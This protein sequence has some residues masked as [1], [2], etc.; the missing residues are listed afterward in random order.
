MATDIDILI[1]ATD[2]ASGPIKKVEGE[3]KNLGATA[4]SSSS[5]LGGL[6]NVFKAGLTTALVGTAAAVGGLVFA[7]KDSIGAAKE[8]AQGQKQLAAVLTST[9][10]AAGVTVDAANDLASSLAKV[11][12][13][14]DDTILAGENMLLTFTNIGKD[15]FPRAT[16]TI[17]DMS[18][19]LGD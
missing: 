19:A 15:V 9:G 18:Q 16:E 5:M 12:N 13:F 4:K 1:K 2:Q 17:L 8:A 11:T 6:G 7:F 14:Q 3:V 10:F